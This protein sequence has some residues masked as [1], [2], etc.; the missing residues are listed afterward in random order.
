MATAVLDAPSYGSMDQTSVMD[1]SSLADKTVFL[2]L[3]FGSFG[4][5]RKVDLEIFKGL[6]ASTSGTS[7]VPSTSQPDGDLLKLT[8]TLLD[9]EELD[10]VR[11]FVGKVRSYLEKRCLPY[12]T[13][14][15][16]LPCGLIEDVQTH[17]TTNRD[18]WQNLVNK[19]LAA[20][21]SL[22]AKAAQQL[23]SLYNPADYP[24]VEAVSKK[25]TFD[26]QYISFGVPGQL[27]GISKA[28][29]DAEKEKQA[30]VLKQATDDITA[31]MR[32]TLLEMTQHLME[33]LTPG[34]DGKPK[35]FRDSAVKN[36]Q[37]FLNNFDLRNVTDDKA[38]ADQVTKLKALI[39]GTD[40]ESLRH[41]DVFRQ[42]IREGMAEVTSVLSTMTEDKADRKF[43]S[44]F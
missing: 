35:I 26:W 38:L 3:R 2:K 15:H 8:K 31:L 33:R 34:E 18:E 30:N 16:L 20:Y 14:I 19:F 44:E 13:G 4:N 43:R 11:K 22:C 36:V 17:L 41:S 42:K 6:I 12:D 40:A 25:F 9:S 29:F 5:S 32:Q 39:S 28:L 24:S 27:K 23:G 10:A 37:E 1:V 21:P 7:E